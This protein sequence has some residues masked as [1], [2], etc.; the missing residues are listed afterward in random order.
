MN[1]YVTVDSGQNITDYYTSN[2]FSPTIEVIQDDPVI[3][4]SKLGHIKSRGKMT[5]KIISYLM[6]QNGRNRST[7]KRKNR[8]LMREPSCLTIWRPHI[9]LEAASDERCL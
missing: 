9:V 5:A 8:P 4:V 1:V 3:D 6:R 7:A 2:K